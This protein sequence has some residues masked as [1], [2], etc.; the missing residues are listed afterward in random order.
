MRYDK[1]LVA[2]GRKPNGHLVAADQAGVNVDERGFIN[3]SNELRTN[4]NHIFAMAMLLVNLCLPTK[5]F[6]K[7]T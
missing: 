6:T 3:V 1:I 2:V 7:R 4:V 5:R